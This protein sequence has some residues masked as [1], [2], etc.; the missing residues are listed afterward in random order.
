M[1][2]ITGESSENIYTHIYNAFVSFVNHKIG[3]RKV[4][5]SKRELMNILK[6]RNLDRICPKLEKILK[7]GEAVRFAPVSSQDAHLDLQEMRQ[8]LKEV[9]HEWF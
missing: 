8:L 2:G 6:T 3:S 4:E 5:Y 7:R 1:F 9:D